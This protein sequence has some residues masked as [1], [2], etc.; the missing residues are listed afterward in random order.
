VTRRLR[1]GSCFVFFV[2]TQT[3]NAPSTVTKGL[4][5]QQ[6]GTEIESCFAAK[7]AAVIGLHDKDSMSVSVSVSMMSLLVAL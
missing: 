2:E 1:L 4:C 5:S 6:Y 3:Q 7:I